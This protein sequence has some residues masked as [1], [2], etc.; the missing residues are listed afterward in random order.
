MLR[1]LTLVLALLPVVVIAPHAP[2]HAATRYLDP[3]FQVDVQ[4]DVVYGHATQIDGT[5]VTLE[6]DVYTPRG[7]TLT[8][9]PAF[10]FAH[11]GFFVAGSRAD[12]NAVEWAKRMASRGWVAASVSYRLGPI[13][14]LAPVDTTLEAQIVNNA[15]ADMQTAVRWMRTNAASLGV[16]SDRI[17]VGGLSA[18]AVTALGVSLNADAPQP[19]DWPDVSSAVCTALSISG[20]ND[21]ALAGPDDA[22]AIFFHGTIDTVVPYE[23]AAATRD[24]ML[25]Q[26]LPARWIE[27]PGEGHSLTD[28]SRDAI[29]QP[30]VEWLYDWVANAKYPCS[31]AVAKQ[32]PVPAGRQTKLEGDAG[33]S[34]VVSL[35][36][37]ENQAA[38]YL[39][40]LP[41]GAEA[42]E[43]SNLNLDAANQI[44]S[45]LAVAQFDEDGEVCVFNQMRTHLV[46]DLQGWFA[47]GAFDDVEDERLL[48]TRF[49]SVAADGSQT[50]IAGRP[51]STAVV[52]LVM[53]ETSAPGYVQVLPC[54]SAPGGSSNL[55]ADAAGQTRATLA[56]VRFDAAG[57]ACVFTQRSAHLVVDLQGYMSPGSFDDIAD[58]R[59]VDTR[60]GVKPADGALTE[61]VGRPNST[62]VVTIVAT[63]TAGPG[64]VQV[65]PCGAA[66]GEYSNLNVDRPSETVAGLAFVR[67]GADGRACLFDQRATHLVADVQGYLADGAFEDVPDQRLLDTRTK[68]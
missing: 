8:D 52:S 9:R 22:G 48:D 23:Q 17:A 24:A 33:R 34:G 63:E 20:A 57:Q 4:L 28:E 18:G 1:R 30:A 39:Q 15:L 59:L 49:G 6:L 53:T 64:Y 32:P 27:F 7:D 26:G 14:V 46:A 35:V 38:G 67:F 37:V 5:P 16:D 19:G 40:V 50:M 3:I 12:R 47:P 51:D 21:P 55:N 62:G 10:L 54:G 58:A 41:C 61:I 13:A 29:V 65:L 36:A 66:P 2:A 43:S 42:G 68:G 44:R 45:V 25:R 56:F 31:P 11:G 60:T